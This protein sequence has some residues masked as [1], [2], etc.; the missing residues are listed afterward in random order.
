MKKILILIDNYLPGH[1]YGGPVTSIHSMCS[2]LANKYSFYI[3]TSNRD[4]GCD[5]EYEIE[6]NIWTNSVS[7]KY[8]VM[9]VPSK[10]LYSVRFLK[11]MLPQFDK[12]FLCG[13]F[14]KLTLLSLLV[15]KK[16]KERRKKVIV[17]P[18]GVFFEGAMNVKKAK[19]KTFIFFAKM[20]GFYRGV[21]WSCTNEAEKQAIKS[22]FGKRETCVVAED[23]VLPVFVGSPS[24]TGPNV[25]CVFISRIC[26]TK[27]LM[28][29]IDAVIKCRSLN[30]TLDIYGPVED[31]D[32][33]SECMTL[34]GAANGRKIRYV[35]D[36]KPSDIVLTFSRYDVF[37]F[38]TVTE[39]FGHVIYE[40]MSGG[41]I[42]VISDRT[43]WNWIGKDG[44]GVVVSTLNSD[45]FSKAIDNL[46]KIG[47]S[48]LYDRK[49]ASLQ[50]AKIFFSKSISRTGYIDLFQD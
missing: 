7:P 6:N 20:I 17:A 26:K 40:A 12:I 11:F 36:V 28:C 27:N 48:E 32:Y 41:C 23:M 10:K 24:P 29:A 44:F 45:A 19:K 16:F 30:V 46:A 3:L 39:N 33:Y 35:G 4:Y 42:P 31:R 9:Y 18:M 37:V 1:R 15:L 47:S 22:V 21:S 49:A 2:N 5:D 38:P 25:R 34:A 8:K 14:S 13:A 50:G 43:P